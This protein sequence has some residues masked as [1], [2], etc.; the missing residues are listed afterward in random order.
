MSKCVAILMIE[1]SMAFN[2]RERN[3]DKIQVSKLKFMRLNCVYNNQHDDNNNNNDNNFDWREH[4]HRQRIVD[5]NKLMKLLLVYINNIFF[6]FIV[7]FSTQKI[8]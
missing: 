6:F 4:I 7:I 5:I 2:C 8:I 3:E 1:H